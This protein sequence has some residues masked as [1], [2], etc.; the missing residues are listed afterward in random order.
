MVEMKQISRVGSRADRL[1]TDMGSVARKPENFACKNAQKGNCP[2]MQFASFGVFLRALS[3]A[4]CDASEEVS[5]FR[6]RRCLERS[7]GSQE[8]NVELSLA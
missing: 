7:A 1:N 5:V 6:P 8:G 4:S 2:K 3:G